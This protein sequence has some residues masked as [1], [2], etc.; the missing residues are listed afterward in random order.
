MGGSMALRVVAESEDLSIS[1]YLPVIQKVSILLLVGWAFW[2]L[3]YKAEH[4]FVADDA[5][6][7]PQ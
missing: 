3:V 4:T 6:I 1:E 2:R 7:Q 5:K